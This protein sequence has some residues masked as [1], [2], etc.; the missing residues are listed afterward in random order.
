MKDFIK[1]F[2]IILVGYFF[3]LL[4]FSALISLY[5]N[6]LVAN[7]F[8]FLAGTIINLLLI[9][10]YLFVNSRF[11]LSDDVFLT[12]VFYSLTLLVSSVMLIFF[13]NI[14]E[15]N[16]Y[17]AKIISNLFTLLLNYIL[18]IKFFTIK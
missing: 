16:P 17:T 1:Y 7:F 18:R 5:F 9:R 2:F 4:L 12:L 10:K 3:D 13:I 14:I 6:V 11:G 8:G 15:F